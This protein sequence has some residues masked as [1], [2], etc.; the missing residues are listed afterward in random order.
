MIGQDAPSFEAPLRLGIGDVAI[1]GPQGVLATLDSRARAQSAATQ[2]PETSA[3]PAW[4]P[5]DLRPVLPVETSA[6][7]SSGWA[8][9][10]ATLVILLFV[11]LIIR[12]ALT[13]RRARSS[14][15]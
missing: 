10:I 3:W 1:V 4:L 7:L 15:L 12:A 13:R 11:L 6:W 2:D 9:P 8:V 14:G 5:A